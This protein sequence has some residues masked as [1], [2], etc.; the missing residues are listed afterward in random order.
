MRPA[1]PGGGAAAQLRLCWR[2]EGPV[3]LSRGMGW[4]WRVGDGKAGAIS[5][6]RLHL[7]RAPNAPCHDMLPRTVAVGYGQCHY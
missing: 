3:L 6:G 2:P 1:P 5:P 7:R 4:A